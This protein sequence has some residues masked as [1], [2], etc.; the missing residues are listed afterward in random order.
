MLNLEVKSKLDAEKVVDRAI[1]R[2][3]EQEGMAITELA[4][5]LHSGEQALDLVL[6]N[7]SDAD[8]ARGRA[9][10]M[11][12]YAH[13]HY[14]YDPVRQLVHFDDTGALARHVVVQVN[15]G[16]P[17]RVSFQSDKADEIVRAFAGSIT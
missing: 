7:V 1:Q 3:A 10:S 14:G 11:I 4:S 17:S 8:E 12:D 5:H 15:V 16:S 6:S 9:N 2:F 13:K